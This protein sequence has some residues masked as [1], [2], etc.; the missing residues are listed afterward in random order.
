MFDVMALIVIQELGIIFFVAVIGITV[1]VWIAGWLDQSTK[2]E[3]PAGIPKE[4]A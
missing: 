4:P 1:S 2:V 3:H